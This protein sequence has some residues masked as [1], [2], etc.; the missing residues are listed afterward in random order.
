MFG[1]RANVKQQSGQSRPRYSDS[2]KSFS[3]RPKNREESSDLDEN[4]TESIAA[5]RSII[6]KKF[7]APSSSKNF[8]N[9]REIVV[10]GVGSMRGAP[11][12]SNFVFAQ[13]PLLPVCSSQLPAER[14]SK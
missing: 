2:T 6:S 11:K 12:I 7:A 10:D 3:E 9:L 5:M 14:S 8:A 1:F 4:L 13:Q